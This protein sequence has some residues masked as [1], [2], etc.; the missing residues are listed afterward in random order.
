MLRSLA[1]LGGA[2]RGCRGRLRRQGGGADVDDVPRP[3]LPEQPTA[4]NFV[5]HDQHGRLSR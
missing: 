4:P 2:R 5:L 1:A 3:L